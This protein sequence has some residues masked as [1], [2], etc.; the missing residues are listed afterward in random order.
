[1]KN[2]SFENNKWQSEEHIYIFHYLSI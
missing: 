1:M 2:C